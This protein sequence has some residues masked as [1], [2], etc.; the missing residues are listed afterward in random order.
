MA[1]MIRAWW[2]QGM[3]TYATLMTLYF[4]RPSY[5]WVSRTKACKSEL[6]RSCLSGYAIGRHPNVKSLGE[7]PFLHDLITLKFHNFTFITHWNFLWSASDC[8]IWLRYVILFV[9]APRWRWKGESYAN[10]SSCKFSTF[11]ASSVGLWWHLLHGYHRNGLLKFIFDG[12]LA[13]RSRYQIIQYK[14]ILVE[15]HLFPNIHLLDF[16]LFT[17]IVV[18]QHW[19]EGYVYKLV[20]FSQNTS[21]TQII[22]LFI[23]CYLINVIGVPYYSGLLHWYWGR[24]VKTTG[25]FLS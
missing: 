16:V 18:D 15:W 12:V 8:T 20:P 7:R 4:R 9:K 2:C 3:D 13:T 10:N 19:K 5:P 17:K 23:C 6:W 24:R 14:E 11:A 25:H 22:Q 1:V 21:H